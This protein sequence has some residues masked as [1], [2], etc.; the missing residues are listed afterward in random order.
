VEWLV[1]PI[2]VED[3]GK[4]IVT[5]YKAA[6]IAS[7]E[8]FYT[9]TNG[10]GLIQRIRDHRDTWE[11]DLTEPISANYYPLNSR[12]GIRDSEHDMWILTDRA[13]G[14]TSMQAGQIEVMVH[15]RLLHDDAFG[16]GEALDEEAFGK[17]LVV[18]GKHRVLVC[19]SNC[20]TTSAVLADKIFAEPVVQFGESC[21][22]NSELTSEEGIELPA[23][24]KLLSMEKFAKSQI[25]VRIENVATAGD[26]IEVALQDLFPASTIES[27]EERTLDGNKALQA[28]D[29]INWT[30]AKEEKFKLPR[31]DVLKFEEELD[32]YLQIRDQDGQT[33]LRKSTDFSIEIEPGFI[34]TYL[35]TLQQ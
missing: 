29:R 12:I 9:D 31:Y 33:L 10:R 8:T 25:L 26:S 2:P 28:V 35:I 1:G 7:G 27:I 17:G 15:R 23:T 11:L 32:L 18:R 6:D 4:E 3:G 16:V 14:G 22:K 34:K 20:D 21:S 24:I 13:E 19:N 30:G 5:R